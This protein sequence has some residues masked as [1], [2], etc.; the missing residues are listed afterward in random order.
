MCPIEIEKNLQGRLSTISRGQL[1]E[2]QNLQN[3][4]SDVDV[5]R[6]KQEKLNAEEAEVLTLLTEMRRK[7]DEAKSKL[8]LIV[9]GHP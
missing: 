9:R 6:L 7:L 1:L 3:L 8:N 2:G 4:D 5:L